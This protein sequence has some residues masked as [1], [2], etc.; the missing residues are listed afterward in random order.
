[1]GIANRFVE[2]MDLFVTVW[3]RVVGRDEWEA[4]ARR[5]VADERWPYATRLLTDTTSFDPA[6]LTREDVVAVATIFDEN[7][8]RLGGTKHAII[9]SRGWELAR[10]FEVQID[11]TGPTT[12]VFNYL[13]GA[14]PWLGVEAGAVVGILDELRRDLRQGS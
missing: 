11:P 13:E 12:I 9:A 10:L 5:Q 3:D 4:M 1:V 8:R 14:C 6:S 7:R 2:S